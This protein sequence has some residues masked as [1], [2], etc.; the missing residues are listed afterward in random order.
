MIYEQSPA[1]G[2]LLKEGAEIK[3]Y[4]SQGKDSAVLD[5]LVGKT[6][7]E[8]K[9]ILLSE[10]LTLGSIKE[11]VSNKYEKNIVINQDPKA[12][13]E[14][15]KK[16]VVNL[17][18]S[19]GLVKSKSISINIASYL[20][21]AEDEEDDNEVEDENGKG[22]DKDKEEPQQV[23]VKV[24]VIDDKNVSTLQYENAHLSNETITVELKG[25][26]VQSYQVQ[27]NNTIYNAEN[28]SF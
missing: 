21:G 9:E 23:R 1:P 8:A 19:K 3:L 10:G 20:Y 26:G 7:D 6:I 13:V 17:T 27:I 28:I 4:V 11:E 24:F 25:I 18:I 16:S 12:G 22:K 15:Q 2:A 5:D 14:L